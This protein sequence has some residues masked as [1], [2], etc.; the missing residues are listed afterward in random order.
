LQGFCYAIA[1]S[2]GGERKATIKAAFGNSVTLA[3][4]AHFDFGNCVRP[5]A[6]SR[7]WKSI[8]CN[9]I[10]A[11]PPSW[12]CDGHL[13]TSELFDQTI[14]TRKGETIEIETRIQIEI[15]Q[16]DV[17]N[18]YSVIDGCG[19]YRM[20]PFVVDEKIEFAWHSETF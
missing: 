19:S 10:P 8:F 13:G 3:D 6:F 14:R 1:L 12:S 7:S 17:L 16:F 15:K 20:A 18:R 4:G 5:R 11:E 9:L 2:L